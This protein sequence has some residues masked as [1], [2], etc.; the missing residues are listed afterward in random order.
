MKQRT[1]IAFSLLILFTTITF[2]LN[3]KIEKFN[4]KEIIIKNNFLIKDQEIRKSL[5]PIYNKNLIFLKNIEIKEILMK[6]SFIEGFKI[7]KKYPQTII[8]EVFEKKPIGVLIDKKKKF[9]IS[10]KIDLIEFKDLQNFKN[11]PLVF[12]DIKDFKEIHNIFKKLKFPL[13]H[14]SK[15]FLL[16]TNRWD[17]KT[18]NNI[19]IRLPA[20]N[21]E[22]S[23]KNYLNLM[24]NNNIKKYRIFDYRINGQLI[25]K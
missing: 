2:Q 16:E 1:I 11:L 17:L 23:L 7:Q 8:I 14:I 9:Y 15:F 24:K 19:T 6:N 22:K 21:Y 20:T 12:G 3:L 13:E 10:E 4:L 25:L 18:R 5:T